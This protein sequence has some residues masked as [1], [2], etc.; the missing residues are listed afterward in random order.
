[1][2]REGLR[3]LALHNNYGILV[4]SEDASREAVE[5]RLISG[6]GGVD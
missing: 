5:V 6:I 4:N 1:M 2:L 3:L